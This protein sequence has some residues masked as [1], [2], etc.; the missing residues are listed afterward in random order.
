MRIVVIGGTATSVMQFR[1]PLLAAMIAQGHR[2][3]VCTPDDEPDIAKRLAEIGVDFAAVPLRRARVAPLAD[4]AALAFIT[5][6]LRRLRPDIVLTYTIK[7]VIYG[8]IAAWL[9][10]VPRRYAMITGLGLPFMHPTLKGRALATV[11]GTLARQALARNDAIFFQN[12][13]DI[14]EFRRRA[15]LHPQARVV[16]LNGSGV[17]LA[18]YPRSAPP[19]PPVTFLWMG[20]LLRDKGVVEF[21]AAVRQL[22]QQGASFRAQILGLFDVNPTAIGRAELDRWVA[23]G[24]VE[25]LGSTKDVRPY[26][27]ACSVL[28]YPSYR[29]GTPRAVLEAM[30]TARPIITTDAPG[31]RETVVEGENGY[32]VPVRDAEAI[33]AAMGRFIDQPERVVTMGEASY[34][35]ACRKYD[36]HKVNALVM[37]TLEL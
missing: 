30:A 15:I 37:A 20:R 36:V 24:T 14:A 23:E 29:E 19:P 13:D 33:A 9:A 21:V 17:D 16:Q 28:V 1:G 10:G 26:L 34:Q 18:H 35:L 31:C 27:A 22:K 12:P 32:L 3:T 8:S 6:L 7:P 4:L 11:V 5:R 25:F 2:V